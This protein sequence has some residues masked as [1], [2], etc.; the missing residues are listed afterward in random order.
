MISRLHTR[1]CAFRGNEQGSI[2]IEA[3]AVTPF[4]VLLVAG[5]VEFGN[6]MHNQELVQTGVRDAARYLARVATPA[7]GETAARNIATTGMVAGGTQRITWW[8]PSNIEITYR[9]T[10]NPVDATTGLRT[11]RGNDPITTIRV[12]TTVT[13]PGLSLLSVLGLDPLQI[14]ATHEERHV[15]E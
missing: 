8:A 3:A 5:V 15:G 4:L 6:I 13:Y 2:A 12:S 14:N 9:Q 11:Y 7:S 10:P 1:F